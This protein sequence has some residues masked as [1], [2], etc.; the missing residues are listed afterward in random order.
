M[1]SLNEIS[2]TLFTITYGKTVLFV[3]AFLFILAFLFFTPI[4]K[5]KKNLKTRKSEIVY[6]TNSIT[7][8]KQK[9]T[10]S[11][12]F[13]GVL[14]VT[15]AL[16]LLFYNYNTPQVPYSGFDIEIISG[17]PS[18]NISQENHDRLSFISQSLVLVK[19]SNQDTPSRFDIDNDY[20]D[21]NRNYWQTEAVKPYWDVS[22]NSDNETWTWYDV[23]LYFPRN[24][25]SPIGEKHSHDFEQ[26][27]LYYKLNDTIPSYIAF[28]TFTGLT[29]HPKELLKWNEVPK[30]GD[31]F[32]LRLDPS[33]NAF[34]SDYDVYPIPNTDN[35]AVRLISPEFKNITDYLSDLEKTIVY[36]SF[37]ACG[38]IFLYMSIAN[39]FRHKYFLL[40]FL[41][42]LAGIYP[43][44]SLQY[45]YVSNASFRVWQNGDKPDTSLWLDSSEGRAYID[46]YGGLPFD[47]DRWTIPPF[48]TE[49]GIEIE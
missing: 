17:N 35:Y 38:A 22:I 7:K 31:K 9:V 36:S 28:P 43:L 29:E 3:I 13:L 15:C 45:D 30:T 18:I 16:I 41:F 11:H 42:F 1:V 4:T 12:L 14:C 33:T 19:Q 10:Y 26:F 27:Y 47:R 37:F 32:Y 6:K 49:L 44:L 8:K 40:L 24:G 21:D 20:L 34:S 46:G 2:N 5:R 39:K 48:S 25:A 23:E